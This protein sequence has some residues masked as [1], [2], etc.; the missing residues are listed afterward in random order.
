MGMGFA[1]CK[2]VI[3][4]A[5]KLAVI[6]PTEYVAFMGLIEKYSVNFDQ[7]AR[8]A[9]C[10]ADDEEFMEI[11]EDGEPLTKEQI[12]EL[13]KAY[14]ELVYAFAQA[15]KVPG[16]SF[17]TLWLNYHDHENEGSRYDDVNGAFFEVG[18]YYMKTPAAEY[19]TDKL[20]LQD[21]AFVQLG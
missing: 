19:W 5:E 15:T 8:L 14:D 10:Q 12:D 2:V 6:C 13:C 18:E 7:Y 21:A 9:T 11:Y 20:N 1:A 17:L 16:G 3:I 4:P